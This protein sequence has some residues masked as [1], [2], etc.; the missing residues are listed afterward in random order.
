MSTLVY[1]LH[2]L[3]TIKDERVEQVGISEW[4][5][6]ITEWNAEHNR[7]FNAIMGTFTQRDPSWNTT[8]IMKYYTPAASKMQPVDEHGVAKPMREKG[9]YQI[10]L[11]MWRREASIGLSYEAM[12]KITIAE[13]SRQLQMV[14]RADL[15][16]HIE[17]FLFSLF[18]EENWTFVSTEDNLPDIPVKALANGDAITY[19]VRGNDT[20]PQTA[21][22]YV[23]S[24]SDIATS[25]PFPNIKDTLT[26]YAGTSANDRIV[27][28][29]GGTTNINQIK[30]LD[31]FY[32]T[33]RTQFTDWGDNVS[34]VDPSADTFIGMGDE[35]LGEH[36]EGVLVVRWR[37]LPANYILSF[38]L[39]AE[40]PIGIREDSTP[41]LQG[42]FPIDAI[43]N[44]GNT[45][46]NRF[47]RK[48]GFAPV[49][50][51]AAMVNYVGVSGTYAEPTA[52]ASIPA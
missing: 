52:Y 33:D 5:D 6:R 17:L 10:G 24:A 43:E 15:H 23:A 22:H 38:N 45:I 42:L 36:E 28:F 1:G 12:K 29:V 8:P 27:S 4:N 40:A 46:L 35:V 14:E 26:K 13:M 32:R 34:L 51:T 39:D 19:T 41:S 48:I 31:G 7:V 21:D 47:R 16:T 2:D 3:E 18:Y 37:K 9:S 50:R 30:A 20:A 11:P 44:S 49:N 25:D